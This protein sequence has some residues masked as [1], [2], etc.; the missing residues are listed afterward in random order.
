MLINGSVI[1]IYVVVKINCYDIIQANTYFIFD[2][3]YG[4]INLQN[5]TALYLLLKHRSEH[6]R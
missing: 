1:F 4:S 5:F 2:V 3:I 6:G